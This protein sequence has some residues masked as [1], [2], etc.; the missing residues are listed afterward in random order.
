MRLKLK[1]IYTVHCG[2][3]IE[4]DYSPIAMHWLKKEKEKSKA[5]FILL[6]ARRKKGTYK[7]V[8]AISFLSS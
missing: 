6:S 3:L 5:I 2:G 4:I 8:D 7:A 1:K